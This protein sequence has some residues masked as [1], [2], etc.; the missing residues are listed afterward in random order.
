MIII[1][2][3]LYINDTSILHQY[4]IFQILKYN[5]EQNEKCKH[6]LKKKKK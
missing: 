6:I 2:S 4:I 1:N 5:T 3:H